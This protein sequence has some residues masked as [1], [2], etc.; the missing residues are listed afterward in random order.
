MR[1]WCA[2]S[3]NPTEPARPLTSWSPFAW[4]TSL[5]R[6]PSCESSAPAHTRG[7]ELSAAVSQSPEQRS[8]GGRVEED[9]V[10]V[11]PRPHRA[12]MASHLVIIYSWDAT[13][14]FCVEG[15]RDRR[16][17]TFLSETRMATY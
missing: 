2:W 16:T 7:R 12:G 4:P 11:V 9:M 10:R 6:S 13:P 3:P 15:L 5:Y 1:T 8:P 14:E 17:P